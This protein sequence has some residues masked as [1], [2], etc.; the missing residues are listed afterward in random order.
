MGVKGGGSGRRGDRLL[1]NM[2][3]GIRGVVGEG[4]GRGE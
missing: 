4:V 1:L 3:G 2:Y